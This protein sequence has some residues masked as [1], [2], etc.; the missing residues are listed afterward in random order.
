MVIWALTVYQ[1]PVAAVGSCYRWRGVCVCGGGGAYNNKNLFFPSSGGQKSEIKLSSVPCLLKASCLSHLLMAPQLVAT[2]P[3][4][5]PLW[6]H[7]LLLV[8]VS[9]CFSLKRTHVIVF[10]A[11]P[12][13]Q[14]DTPHLN[15]LN[16]TDNCKNCFCSKQGKVYRESGVKA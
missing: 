16:L 2:S 14:D 8:S 7:C 9:L 12:N 10:R 13:N 1:L 11:C 15:I 5:L 3:L 6:P 4:S